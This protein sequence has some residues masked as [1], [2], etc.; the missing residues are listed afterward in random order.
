MSERS[1]VVYQSLPREFFFWG[2]L[3]AGGAGVFNVLELAPPRGLRMAIREINASQGIRILPATATQITAGGA[4][5]LV[6]ATNP[7]GFLGGFARSGTR[8]DAGILG[9]VHVE[10]ARNTRDFEMV[11]D[12]VES[13]RISLIA[14]TGNAALE[15]S[16]HGLLVPS[17]FDTGNRMVL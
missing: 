5:L 1:D 16:I 4:D 8:G 17:D 13:Q 10:T 14:Q 6:V 2:S 7:L 3:G 9:F 11:L 12:S 15:V